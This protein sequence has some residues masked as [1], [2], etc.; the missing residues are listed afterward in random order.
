MNRTAIQGTGLEKRY[1]KRQVLRGMDIAIPE[2]AI[3]AILGPNVDLPA[4]SWR[5]AFLAA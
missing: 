5:S 4:D 3:T 1:G 2:G